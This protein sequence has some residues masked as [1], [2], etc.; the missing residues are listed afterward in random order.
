MPSTIPF[1]ISV[2]LDWVEFLISLPA[3]SL[4]ISFNRFSTAN[5]VD[6]YGFIGLILEDSFIN[7]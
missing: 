3:Y 2:T 7:N 4:E 1:S 6:P 5:L